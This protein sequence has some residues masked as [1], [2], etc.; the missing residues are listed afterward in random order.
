MFALTATDLTETNRDG[1]NA[2]TKNV[3]LMMAYVNST[4]SVQVSFSD[5]FAAIVKVVK[6][7]IERRRVFNQ[8]LYELRNLSE[9]DLSDLG[10]DRSSLVSVAREAAY[11]A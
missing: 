4:R 8:T 5:R 3:R 7:Q 2:K 9:R 1:P 11:G 10:M 6:D